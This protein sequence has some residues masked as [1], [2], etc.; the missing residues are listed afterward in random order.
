MTAKVTFRSRS[1]AVA[2]GLQP[3]NKNPEIGT[4]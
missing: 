4:E 2:G 3:V 1:F